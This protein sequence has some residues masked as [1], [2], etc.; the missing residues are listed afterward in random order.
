MGAFELGTDGPSAL[1]VGVDGSEGSLR[2]AAYALGLARRQRARLFAVYARREPGAFL[3]FGGTA[4]QALVEAQSEI[5]SELLEM[6]DQQARDWSVD[7]RLV[8][9]PGDPLRVLGDVAEEVKASGIIVGASAGLGH[10][11][12]GSLATRLVRAARWPVTVVP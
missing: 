8:V 11:I 9:R 1:V 4:V 2:A 5:E 12:A 7:A 3:T 6:L 10:K